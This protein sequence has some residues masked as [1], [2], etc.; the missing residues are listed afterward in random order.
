MI[1][2][3]NFLVIGFLIIGL[4]SSIVYYYRLVYYAIF[5]IAK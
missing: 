4:S 5:D 3:N 2:T 1:Q